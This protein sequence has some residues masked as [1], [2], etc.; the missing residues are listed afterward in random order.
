VQRPLAIG[1]LLIAAVLV[2][3]GALD[4]FVLGLH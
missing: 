3:A 1:A 2:V 4:F